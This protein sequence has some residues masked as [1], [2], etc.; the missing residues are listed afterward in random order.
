[1]YIINEA[2]GAAAKAKGH[3]AYP[4]DFPRLRELPG[5]DFLAWAEGSDWHVETTLTGDALFQKLRALPELDEVKAPAHTKRVIELANK[6]RLK[7]NAY[8]A[9]HLPGW[10][11]ESTDWARKMLEQTPTNMSYDGLR[12]QY[13]L[14]HFC[15]NLHHFLRRPDPRAFKGDIGGYNW[16]YQKYFLENTH[17]GLNKDGRLIQAGVNYDSENLIAFLDTAI[18][19]CDAYFE[20]LWASFDDAPFDDHDDADMTLSKGWHCFPVGTERKVIWHWFDECHSKGIAYLLRGEGTHDSTDVKKVVPE[21][22]LVEMEAKYGFCSLVDDGQLQT[23]ILL[24]LPKLIDGASDTPGIRK[25]YGA[26]AVPVNGS[27]TVPSE[28]AVLLVWDYADAY[29]NNAVPVVVPV[30]KS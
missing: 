24:E 30:G 10:V 21:I 17:T 15:P 18:P 6:L 19:I 1:M 20:R 3:A 27:E 29:A 13:I 14:N 5:Q 11:H 7:E 25:L 16:A 4:D 8:C 12:L 28:D 22:D 9:E 2:P 23:Y 26:Y